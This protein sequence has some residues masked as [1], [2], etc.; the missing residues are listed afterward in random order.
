MVQAIKAIHNTDENGRPAGGTTYAKGL[1]LRWQ[2]G[3]LGRGDER[4]EPNGTFVETVIS[5]ALDRL[6]WYQG[7]EFQCV[8]NQ[9]AIDALRVALG[10]LEKR[11]AR[12]EAAGVEGTH[13]GQ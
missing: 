3:P 8:E 6:E 5:A 7:T 11:T 2:N 13:E 9:D 4:Q 10:H 12:R 1:S